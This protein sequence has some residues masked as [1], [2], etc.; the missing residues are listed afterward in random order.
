[1]S[2][3]NVTPIRPG[4]GDAPVPAVDTDGLHFTLTEA[5]ALVD[6]I[7][8]AHCADATEGL[9]Q[10]TIA[11]VLHVAMEKLEHALGMLN[12][13]RAQRQQVGWGYGSSELRQLGT[14]PDCQRGS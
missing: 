1:M 5:H 13:P 7:Y 11:T 3:D 6:T 2:P 14:N 12:P 8:T 4:M 10:R 9:E